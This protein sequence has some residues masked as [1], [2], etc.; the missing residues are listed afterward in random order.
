MPLIESGLAHDEVEFHERRVADIDGDSGDLRGTVA[1]VRDQR[2]AGGSEEAGGGREA[3]GRA[4]G[5]H[6]RCAVGGSGD[7]VDDRIVFLI[8]DVLIDRLDDFQIDVG[9]H[10]P[11]DSAQGRRLVRDEAEILPIEMDVRGVDGAVAV[12]I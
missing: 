5:G 4:I 2:E 10:R 8:T 7:P 3:D 6:A 1:I 12:E 11:F 9:F